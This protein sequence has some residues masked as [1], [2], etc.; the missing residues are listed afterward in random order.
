MKK[1]VRIKTS[2]FSGLNLDRFVNRF[3]E[4]VQALGANSN[5]FNNIPFTIA[6]LGQMAAELAA[7][8]QKAKDGSEDDRNARDIQ[9]GACLAALFR[10]AVYVEGVAANA[11][12]IE[13]QVAIIELAKFTPV[14]LTKT[15]VGQLPAPSIRAEMSGTPG[16]AQLD[17]GPRA[18]GVRY[19]LI[20]HVPGYANEQ[21][22]WSL[23][24]SSPVTRFDAS[25]LPTGWHSFRATCVGAA[26]ES[27]PSEIVHVY[28]F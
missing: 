20:Q 17:F 11:D 12:T 1:N 9:V 19:Y 18:R 25:G 4:I 16:K 5:V 28:V 14:K 3:G 24:S 27:D 6:V 7:K 10:L 26:G 22:Q 23:Y 8:V 21:S 2:D 15:S 13:E